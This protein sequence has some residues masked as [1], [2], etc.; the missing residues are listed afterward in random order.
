[1][2]LANMHF[3]NC[4]MKDANF[5]RADLSNSIFENCD[6]RQANFNQTNLFKTDFRTAFNYEIDPEFN[7]MKK[8]KFSNVGLA[9]LLTKYELEI[10]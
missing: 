6:L 9:G 3:Y 1:M 2:K 4:S 8:T 7:K 5:E 10:E